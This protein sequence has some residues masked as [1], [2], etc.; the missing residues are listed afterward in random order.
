MSLA[1]ILTGILFRFVA[2]YKS[3]ASLRKK[4]DWRLSILAVS[5]VASLVNMVYWNGL[6]L[7]E[8]A[9][10]P[11]TVN[12]ISLCYGVVFLLAVDLSQHHLAAYRRKKQ[13]L[14]DHVNLFEQFAYSA[15]LACIIFQENKIVFSNY[16]TSALTGYSASELKEIALHELADEQ[17]KDYL[18]NLGSATNDE[19]TSSETSIRLLSKNGDTRWGLATF[20]SAIYNGKPAIVGTILDVTH[21]K[22]AEHAIQEAE[23]RLRIAINASKTVVWDVDFNK[24]EFKF[25]VPENL[26]RIFNFEE[27]RGKEQLIKYI[28]EGDRER[29]ERSLYESIANNEGFEAEYRRYNLKG[30][31]KWWRIDGRAQLDANGNPVR[32]TGTG[33]CIHQQKLAAEKVRE[34]EARLRLAT[35]VAGIQVWEWDVA[36]HDVTHIN[37]E[38]ITTCEQLTGFE[39]FIKRVHP[40]HV[41]RVVTSVE[42]SIEQGSRYDEE[43]PLLGNDGQYWWQHSIGQLLY[44][45]K[46]NPVQM[47]GAAIDTTDRHKKDELIHFQADLLDKIEQSVIVQNAAGEITF[48]NNAAKEAFGIEHEAGVPLDI[49]DKIQPE[50]RIVNKTEIMDTL[51]KGKQWVG[52]LT[53]HTSKGASFPIFLSAS[54]LFNEKN[55]FE[56]FIGISSDM[57]AYKEIQQALESS[58]ERLRLAID[59]ANLVVWDVDLNSG[60]VAYNLP[61]SIDIS[62]AEKFKSIDAILTNCHRDD[63]EQASFKL[64]QTMEKKKPFSMEHRFIE[65]D[66]SFEWWES[67]GKIYEDKAGNPARMIG[68]SQVITLR[69]EAELQLQERMH[70]LQ[71]IYNVA[72]AVNKS[73]TLEAI[74]LTAADGAKNGL[75]TDRVTVITFDEED[76]LNFEFSNG[77][78]EEFIASAIEHCPWNSRESSNDIIH[79]ADLSDIDGLDEMKAAFDRA[80]IRALAS[81]P[82]KHKDQI[83]G[84][85]VVYYNEYRELSPSENQ[86]AT[87]IANHISLAIVKTT[88]ERALKTSEAKNKAMLN[89]LP[90][91]VFN[92]NADGVF[93]Y[94]KAHEE[95]KLIIPRDQI[96]GSR[97]L[98]VLPPDLGHLVQDRLTTTVKTRTTQMIEYSLDLDEQTRFYEARF[99]PSGGDSVVV[100]IRDITNRRT[101]EYAL[102]NRTVELQTIADTIPD[103]IIRIGQDLK[104]KFANKATLKAVGLKLEEFVGNDAT[105]FGCPPALHD[106]WI[107]TINKALT[108]KKVRELE[109]DA[110]HPA[111]GRQSFHVLFAPEILEDDTVES[112]LAVIRNVTEERRLQQTIIDISA[113]Q[114]RSIGQDLHDELGQLLTGIG[115][116]IA[117]LQHDLNEINEECAIQTREISK[118]VEKAIGQT[119]TLA[120]GLNPVTLEVHG[121]RAGLQ[122][123]AINTEN[124]FGVDCPFT[125]TEDFE[126]EDEE[127]AVQLYRIGQEAVNNAI[128]HGNATKI[129][130]ELVQINGKAELV[131]RDNGKGFTPTSAQTD[132]HGLRIMNYRARVIGAAFDINSKKN[133]GT[134]VRC[135]FT[136]NIKQH[137]S[138]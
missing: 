99:A 127:M 116:K 65:E 14:T 55:E 73:D 138:A 115:F 8:Y 105:T 40:D 123:L 91:I 98:D 102:R 57:S 4:F 104:M 9:E 126:I 47:I 86:L 53:A 48:S 109:F 97:F 56:G 83:L 62:I 74:Y 15:P 44:N 58:E 32:L 94:Y 76:K 95:H 107:S 75:G 16:A 112:V 108:K 22:N 50:H 122:K 113:R 23:E 2:L 90:D 71:A 69:K 84:K 63:R 31:L 17:S 13:A 52:E 37:G 103:C 38:E 78:S 133:K 125:C 130:I 85:F 30:E 42:Q 27:G 5:I 51:R 6:T 10:M 7:S 110:D 89:A 70:Q 93:T 35:E 54:P 61:S 34:N 124:T 121:L 137:S 77:L 59:A 60:N 20:G 92:I 67:S 134:V 111:E 49:S 28:F 25:I 39:D 12:I 131:V 29:V 21:H 68:T 106:K 18:L 79:F 72:D 45:E 96:I 101:I 117:G 43:F 88:D 82:L 135:K 36:S 19:I 100:V 11:L 136:N 24:E 80:G 3:V 1:F 46:G 33:R 87:R 119:R 26:S 64:K 129:D 118:L 81:F 41:D 120:E 66:R 132:G 128:K 114:Q